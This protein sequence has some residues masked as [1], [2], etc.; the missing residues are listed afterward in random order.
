M[1]HYARMTSVTRLTVRPAISTSS[2]A[3]EMAAF[4][5]T[6]GLSPHPAGQPQTQSPVLMSAL[7]DFVNSTLP[8]SS[9]SFHP[10]E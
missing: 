3:V 5:E 2:R 1:S 9:V 10:S 6:E 7:P 4:F 8:P